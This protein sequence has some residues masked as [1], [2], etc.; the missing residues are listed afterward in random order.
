MSA[1]PRPPKRR[2]DA[3]AGTRKGA[4]SLAAGRERGRRGVVAG[5]M[6]SRWGWG[7][8]VTIV[9]DPLDRIVSHFAFAARYPG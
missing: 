8:Y 3:A 6:G 9:R 4:T 2:G 5:A 7:R 1:V